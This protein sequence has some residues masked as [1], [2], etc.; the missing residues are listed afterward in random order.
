MFALGLH[1]D[2]YINVVGFCSRGI[3]LVMCMFT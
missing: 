3:K 1:A 2:K